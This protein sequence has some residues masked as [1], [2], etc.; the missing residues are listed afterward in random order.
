MQAASLITFSQRGGASSTSAW[1]PC[2][3]TQEAEDGWLQPGVLTEDETV[4]VTAELCRGHSCHEVG[5]HSGMYSMSRRK[6]K[7]MKKN[8]VSGIRITF[9]AH[10]CWVL[11][12]FNVFFFYFYDLWQILKVR[13]WMKSPRVTDRRSDVHI[14]FTCEIWSTRRWDWS[15]VCGWGE[16]EVQ[17]VAA[18]RQ[19]GSRT[20]EG[21]EWHHRGDQVG[22]EGAWEYSW[23]HSRWKVHS[24]CHP[25]LL[26]KS[27]KPPTKK[28]NK[29]PP[30]PQILYTVHIS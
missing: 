15:W 13:S 30:I 4:T 6:K 20:N 28:I 10:S 27:L 5:H 9:I 24:L 26:L 2:A 17:I 29:P 1:R 22:H 25:P 7:I 18:L 14:P 3:K 16:L 12:P 19:T 21:G 11:R 23:F 8:P